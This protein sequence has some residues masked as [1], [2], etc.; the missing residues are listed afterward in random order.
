MID[1]YDLRAIRDQ[2]PAV[3]H[4]VYMNTGTAGPLP[5]EAADALGEAFAAQVAR[6]RI[7]P[8]AWNSERETAATLR[9]SVAD[10]LHSGPDTVALTHH[11]TD[12]LNAA[13]LGMAW[14]PGDVVLTTDC[15]HAA[16]QL[17]MGA[18]RLRD[19]VRVKV[20]R[21]ADADGPEEMF[22]RIRT[23]MDGRVRAVFLSH[24]SYANG[25]VLPLGEIAAAASDR[26]VTTV[27]D[28]AQAV[29]A[30]QVLPEELGVDF[31]ALPGQKWL[32]G[33]EGTG[34]LWVAPGRQQELRPGAIGYASVRSVDNEGYFLPQPGARR[35]EVGTVFGPG[36]AGWSASLGWLARIGWPEIW[37]RTYDLAETA[38]LALGEI[39]GVSVL[40]PPGHAGLVSFRIEGVRAEAAVEQLG[41]AGF[42]VRSIPGWDAVRISCGFFLEED[43]VERL[44]SE[45]S[46]L[47][48]AV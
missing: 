34:A 45:V 33:P 31:Y 48:P 17:V 15:E 7:D 11:T 28:G 12:G 25:A 10:L 18:L 43:E 46:A 26:G 42:R 29:G 32:L 9:Q 27:V 47:G 36:L 19:G 8:E 6:G 44:V 21:L 20:A 35:L 22:E 5:E 16:I 1:A 40:T 37:A 2:L 13:A 24:V 14:Q 39:P 41:G 23:E 3:R 38:R 4:A 30:M